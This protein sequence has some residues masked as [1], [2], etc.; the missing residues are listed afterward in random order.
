MTNADI[1]Y[2]FCGLMGWEVRHPFPPCAIDETV[3]GF[4]K[5]LTDEQLQKIAVAL[6]DEAAD[7]KF[8]VDCF[9]RY[10]S[11]RCPCEW[12]DTAVDP[13]QDAPR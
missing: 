2:A 5:A 4:A 3:E 9:E 7:R 12:D 13:L 8:C 6:A 1:Y 10:T 11:L